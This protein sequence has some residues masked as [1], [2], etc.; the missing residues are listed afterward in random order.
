[1][2]FSNN[3]KFAHFVYIFFG[4]RDGIYYYQFK[5]DISAYFF[6]LIIDY[7]KISDI[8]RILILYDYKEHFSH[9]VDFDS[10]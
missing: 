7:I 2:F 3:H 5:E 10:L 9:I 8:I 4:G 1:M 6:Q